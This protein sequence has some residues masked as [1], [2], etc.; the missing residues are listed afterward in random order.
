MSSRNNDEIRAHSTTKAKTVKSEN[1]ETE[2]Y[3]DGNP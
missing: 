3:S 1:Y 2:N